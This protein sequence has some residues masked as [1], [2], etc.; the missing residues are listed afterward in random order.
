MLSRTQQKKLEK[1]K[2]QNG[3]NFPNQTA[4]RQRE[5]AYKTR[6]PPPDYSQVISLDGSD[7]RLIPLCLTRCPHQLC[8][9]F[10][11]RETP[12]TAYT[13]RQVP[14]LVVLPQILSPRAQ[15]SLIMHIL[16]QEARPPNTSNLDAHYVMPEGGVWACVERDTVRGT[17]TRI[18]RKHN[19]GET[20]EAREALRHMRWTTM[21]YQY[22]WSA[23]T[24][25][26]TQTTALPL[27][28]VDMTRA[29]VA[30]IDEAR[31]PGVPIYHYAGDVYHPEAGVV[32]YYHDRDTLTAH[33]DHSEQNMDAPL[34]SFSLGNACVFL[35]GS[36]DLSDEPVALRLSSGDALVMRGPCRRAYHGVPR[37]LED[38]SPSYFAASEW[39]D[40]QHLGQLWASYAS[41]VRINVNVR[42]VR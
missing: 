19:T 36:E 15:R 31:A 1:L 2:Q 29:I 17:Q 20:L 30:S 27:C 42:Q 18:P 34:V 22:D 41:K 25:P 23:K 9:Q 10:G 28:L 4:F 33:V 32:N 3:D 12:Q 40:P 7:E 6:V 16:R 24:Y 38:T 14:G 8:E 13:L 11:A 5:R 35:I 26:S 21:G 37:I 39:E